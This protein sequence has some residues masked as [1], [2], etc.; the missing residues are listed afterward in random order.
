MTDLVKIEYK[1]TLPNGETAYAEYTVGPKQFDHIKGRRFGLDEGVFLL[2]QV[3]DERAP[4][5]EGRGE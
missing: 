5:S 3:L 1:V 2:L 4:C